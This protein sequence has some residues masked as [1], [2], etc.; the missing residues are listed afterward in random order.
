MTEKKLGRK[1]HGLFRAIP[2]PRDAV[3]GQV[4]FGRKLGY[5]VVSS[6]SSEVI[7]EVWSGDAQ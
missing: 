5:T 3:S 6:P 4:R 1:I 7:E 2:E